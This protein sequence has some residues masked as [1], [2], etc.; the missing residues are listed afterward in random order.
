MSEQAVSRVL[1]PPHRAGDNDHSSSP[2]V[3]N[4]IERPTRELGRT[5]LD[6]PLFG[7]APGGVCLAPAVTGGTGEL[8]PHRFTLT[9]TNR[10][11]GRSAFCGTFL[12]VARTGRYPAPCPAEPG[13]SSP[14]RRARQR[15]FVLLRHALLTIAQS[16]LSGNPRLHPSTRFDCS[17]DRSSAH[18]RGSAR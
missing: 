3:A 9:L 4:G 8:L 17:G 13:L 18:S 7:L 6:A 5:T 2:G 10:S 16:P 12:P 15:S 11:S 1:F 14:L